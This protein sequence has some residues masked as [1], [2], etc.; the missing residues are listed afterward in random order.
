MR[1]SRS[2][3]VLKGVAALSA[4]ACFVVAVA[5]CGKPSGPP[6]GKVFG[7]VTLDG[8]PLAD[9][10]IEFLPEHGRP[11]AA[12]TDQEGKYTLTYSLSQA[13]AALGTHTVRITTG[14]ER[15][16]PASGKMKNYPEL[17]P[18]KYNTASQLKKEIKAGDNEIHF[19]LSSK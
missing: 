11:S 17:V 16:D 1:N 14:G 9:A 15:P 5:G 2:M 7:K 4:A 8:K 10:G 18:A 3:R 12:R 13:G 6:T 19:E